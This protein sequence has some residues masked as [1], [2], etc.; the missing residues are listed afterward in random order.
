M[1]HKV[2]PYVDGEIYYCNWTHIISQQGNKKMFLDTK[3]TH[4]FENTWMSHHYQLTKKNQL[5]G[6][7]LLLTPVEHERFDHYSKELRKES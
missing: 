5:R 1:S 2:L 7:L 3:W 6:G 4:P